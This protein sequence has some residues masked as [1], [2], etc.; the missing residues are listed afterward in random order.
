MKRC[1]PYTHEKAG[2]MFHETDREEGYLDKVPG[3]FPRQAI[4]ERR[5]SSSSL[6]MTA[7]GRESCDHT[8]VPCFG[9][10]S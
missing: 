3:T 4:A 10:L 1:R 9:T 5:G 7:K 6:D 8:A 2:E